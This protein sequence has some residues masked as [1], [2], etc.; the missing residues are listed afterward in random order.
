MLELTVAFGADADHVGHDGAGDGFL[1]WVKL[2]L[3]FADSAGGV[4]EILDAPDGDH[5]ALGHC[6]L[7]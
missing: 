5:D 4:R 2:G 6:L 1:L 7:R 3:L